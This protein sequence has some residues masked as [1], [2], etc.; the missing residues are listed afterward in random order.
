VSCHD[1]AFA[2]HGF[3]TEVSPHHDE[4]WIAA[5]GHN[6]TTFGTIGAVEDFSALLTG[7]DGNPVIDVWQFPTVNVFWESGDASAPADAVTGLAADSV[8]TCADCHTGFEA[9]GPH[10]ADDYWGIDPDYS[11]PFY[12]AE[13][14][15]NTEEYPSGI[16]IRTDLTTQTAYEDGSVM[17]ICSKCHDL[18]NYASGTTSD[19]VLP[20]I[21]TGG[22]PFYHEKYE[23]TVTP[24]YG[25]YLQHGHEYEGWLVLYDVD[26]HEP[27]DPSVATSGTVVLPGYAYEV[28]AATGTVNTNAIGASNTAHS[29][30]HQ[31]TT[32]GSAQCVNCHVAVPHGWDTPRL[33]VNTGWNGTVNG[34]HAGLIE[35]DRAPYR[36]PYVLGT[37][38]TEDTAMLLDPETGYN[39][40]GALT[41]PASGPVDF[42][43]GAAV[44]DRYTCEGCGHHYHAVQERDGS[45]VRII[46]NKSDY[47]DDY[48]PPA[49]H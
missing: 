9:A 27:V 22:E 18:Q 38:A 19:T 48:V 3:A 31:D 8:V 28:Q 6:T 44:W 16:K 29:S 25:P 20:E 26:T 40:M 23:T 37:T 36:S 49:D 47:M 15:K 24:W 46:T 14:T 12:M 35:G 41:W 45:N 13:L 4:S 5:S 11:A 30:H 39:G 7:T 33:L 1:D 32:D 2:P 43:N 21:S 17:T 42:V 34:I 10:G